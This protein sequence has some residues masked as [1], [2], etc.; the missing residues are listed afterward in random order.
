MKY[1]LGTIVLS[2]VVY[3]CAPKSTTEVVKEVEEVEMTTEMSAG[4]AIY[5][6][7]CIKCHGL[8]VVENYTKAQWEKI[9]PAMME[10]AKLTE[11][12][13]QKVHAYVFG[14]IND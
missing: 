13:R 11:E 7:S 14:T 5:N 4:K 2:V 1:L 3:A 12:D 9:L 8:K 6:T 10:K